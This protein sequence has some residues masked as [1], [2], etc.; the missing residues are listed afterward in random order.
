MLERPG[1]GKSGMTAM[2]G[3]MTAAMTQMTA[4]N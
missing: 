4:G 2:T 1:S 3:G